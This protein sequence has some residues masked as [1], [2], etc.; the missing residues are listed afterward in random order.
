MG[1]IQAIIT[2]RAILDSALGE[3]EGKKKKSAFRHRYFVEDGR[4]RAKRFM[5]LKSLLIDLED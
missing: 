4:A 5:S 1:R 2:D 3:L